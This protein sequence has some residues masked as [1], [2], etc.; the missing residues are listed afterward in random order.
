[1]QGIL[2]AEFAVFLEGKLFLYL[3]LVAL[4]V[5]GD[6][7]ACGTLHFGHVFLDLA[8]K[9]KINMIQRVRALL[10]VSFYFPSTPGAIC[11]A[12][13]DDPRFTKPLLY[14]LS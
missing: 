9:N 1:M 13:T 14:Q 5:M 4:G 10:Y 3:L 8:H 12:R 11:R 7:T 2:L 6:P